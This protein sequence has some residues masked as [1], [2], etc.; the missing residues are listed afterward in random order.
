[1]P[2]V[3]IVTSKVVAS[4]LGSYLLASNQRSSILA[5]N[6]FTLMMC[7]LAALIFKFEFQNLIGLMTL[8]WVIASIEICAAAC[9]IKSAFKYKIVL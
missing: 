8:L 5:I 7:V 2:S 4:A 6:F 9:Y 3:I 1:M